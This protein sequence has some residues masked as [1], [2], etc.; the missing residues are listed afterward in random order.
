MLFRSVPFDLGEAQTELRGN[1]GQGVL[2]VEACDPLHGSL[3][4]SGRTSLNVV[5]RTQ[6]RRAHQEE[7]SL[8]MLG[9]EVVQYL[10]DGV[11]E[12]ECHVRTAQSDDFDVNRAAT[13]LFLI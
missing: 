11:R 3:H 13:P 6:S 9:R 1:G 4:V 7:C 8:A 12:H 10:A 2:D 5:D